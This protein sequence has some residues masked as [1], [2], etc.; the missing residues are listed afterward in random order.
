M[1]RLLRYAII[2]IG[3]GS[4]SYLLILMLHIQDV[5][6]TSVNIFSILLMSAGIGI[7]SI[8]FDIE[9]LNFLTALGIH[10]F[11]TLALVITMMLFNGW[12]DSV[13]NS[14]GF[15]LIFLTIYIAVW[16]LYR[17]QL[18]LN[19]EKMNRVLAQHRKNKQ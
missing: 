15:W 7:L 19:V 1:K 16:A 13:I 14:V 5:P 11:A 4:F 12:I 3:Y 2:G 17:I 18:Y 6:P 8:L 10:F 9:N